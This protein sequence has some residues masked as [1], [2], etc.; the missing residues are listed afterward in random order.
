MIEVDVSV[1]KTNLKGEM[2]PIETVVLLGKF[3]NVLTKIVVSYNGR[4][5]QLHDAPQVGHYIVVDWFQ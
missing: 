5:Y 1:M 4:Q 3:N 2:F